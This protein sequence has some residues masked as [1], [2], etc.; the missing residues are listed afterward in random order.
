MFTSFDTL[1]ELREAVYLRGY[2]QKDPY[3][4]F[5]KEAFE[6]FRDFFRGFREALFGGLSGFSVSGISPGAAVKSGYRA[7]TA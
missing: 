4:E 5:E 7:I 6:S 1:E 3:C 2:A